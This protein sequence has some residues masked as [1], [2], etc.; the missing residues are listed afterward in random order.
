ME[1][2]LLTTIPLTVFILT[3]CRPGPMPKYRKNWFE[4]THD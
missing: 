1:F 4:I 2:V 3:R